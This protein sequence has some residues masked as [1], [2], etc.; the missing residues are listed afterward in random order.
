M[1]S[2]TP[3]DRRCTPAAAVH[4]ALTT[5][6]G[7][8]GE[9][10]FHILLTQEGGEMDTVTYISSRDGLGLENPCL[11]SRGRGGP[12]LPPCTIMHAMQ[13]WLGTGSLSWL[14]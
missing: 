10:A 14:V 1:I 3:G 7:R 2:L 6:E 4:L 13:S 11:L 8:Y 9:G 5:R 12:V